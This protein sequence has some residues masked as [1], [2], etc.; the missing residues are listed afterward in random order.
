M[1]KSHVSTLETGFTSN[2]GHLDSI[3][4]GNGGHVIACRRSSTKLGFVDWRHHLLL[5]VAPM[6]HYQKR[7]T[8]M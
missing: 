3:G 2:D 4:L 8:G 6:P 5:P 7:M 1:V